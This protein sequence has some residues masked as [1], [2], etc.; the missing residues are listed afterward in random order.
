MLNRLSAPH[1]WKQWLLLPLGCVLLGLV[2]CE[3][4]KSID[5]QK[6]VDKYNANLFMST[7]EIKDQ[8]LMQTIEV[9]RAPTSSK[10]STTK[11]ERRKIGAHKDDLIT[12]IDGKSVLNGRITNRMLTRFSTQP[13]SADT[14][15]YSARLPVPAGGVSNLLQFV[16]QSITYPRSGIDAR[17]E[18]K[19]WVNFIVNKYGQVTE[20]S[21]RRGI[22]SSEHPE[23]AEEMNA[24]AL[25]VIKSFPRWVPGTCDGEPVGVAFTIPVT[26]ALE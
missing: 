13:M 2:A 6:A 26:Y 7:I 4:N 8:P 9:R 19:V 21:I 15:V 5:K 24:E 20:T 23:A 18:G 1:R 17:L 12:I 22:S 11:G 10:Y 16:E 14:G 3:K 25:R